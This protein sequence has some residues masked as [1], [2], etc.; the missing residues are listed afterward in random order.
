MVPFAK[1]DPTASPVPTTRPLN[2]LMVGL[3]WF[4]DNPGGAGRYMADAAHGLA[5]RGH[6]VAVVVPRLDAQSPAAERIGNVEVR[7]FTPGR[8]PAKLLGALSAVKP[9]LAERGPFD[10][11]HSHHAYFSAAPLWHPSLASA[12]HV[13]Q[14]QGP[15]AGESVVEGAGAVGRLA[16]Y[17]IE[18]AAYAR[19]D[20]FITLSEAFKALLARDY[21]VNPDRIAVVP[22]AVDL[23]RFRPAEDCA[24]V[25]RAL[26]WGDGPVV[27][28]MRRLVKRMGLEVLLDAFARIR[29][30]VPSARLVIGGTGPLADELRERAE[31]LMIAEAVTFTGRLSDEDL[32]RHYQAADLTVVPTIAL[33][34]FGLVTVESLACGT[35]VLGTSEGGTAEILRG[36]SPDLLVP[37]GD[38]DALAARLATA[39][40]TPDSLP[41][42]AACRLYAETHYAWTRVLDA[43]ET[44]LGRG[45][46]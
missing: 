21:A 30:R 34:G 42:R 1:D 31:A 5:D 27:F 15:W 33:E 36:F 38:V 2:V 8:G 9:L 25:R 37:P 11:V 19:C 12:R 14:F 4:G 6:R 20:R 29:P 39:L 35:P 44:E 7:R 43:L 26:G 23:D 40:T 10:V 13:C 22:A 32:V 24:A 46:H 17:A 28:V 41:D 45:A 18:R 16:K 3:E